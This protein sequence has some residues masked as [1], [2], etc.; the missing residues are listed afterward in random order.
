MEFGISDWLV[1][2]QSVPPVTGPH[3]A[4][5]FG[6]EQSRGRHVSSSSVVKLSP[7]G[8]QAQGPHFKMP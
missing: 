2:Q 1:A 4:P 5:Y 8:S 7:L 3:A 6:K